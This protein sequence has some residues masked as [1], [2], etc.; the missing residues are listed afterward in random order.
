MSTWDLKAP[1]F[2]GPQGLSMFCFLSWTQPSFL[3]LFLGFHLRPPLLQVCPGLLGLLRYIL[4]GPTM[5]ELTA[6][7]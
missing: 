1:H 5:P 3:S 4:S 7:I 6:P 2:P